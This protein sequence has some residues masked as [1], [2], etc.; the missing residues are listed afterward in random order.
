MDTEEFAATG[1][2]PEFY[3]YIFNNGKGNLAGAA[4]KFNAEKAARL[5]ANPEA[6]G[7]PTTEVPAN[8][9]DGTATV[10]KSAESDLSDEDEVD[11]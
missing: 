6:G 3:N 7:A 2:S 10:P 4:E 1:E 8:A 5:L 11:K 9:P